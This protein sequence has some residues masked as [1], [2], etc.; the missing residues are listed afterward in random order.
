MTTRSHEAWERALLEEWAAVLGTRE[1][2]GYRFL[3]ACLTSGHARLMDVAHDLAIDRQLLSMR[4]ANARLGSALAWFRWPRVL[5]AARLWTVAPGLSVLRIAKQVGY[6][7]EGPFRLA[8]QRTLGV[9]IREARADWPVA[10]VA[11][12]FRQGW[13]EPHR[14]TLAEAPLLAARALGGR[15][16][17]LRPALRPAL[18]R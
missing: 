9:E 10:R 3:A 13:L 16:P 8:V 18:R 15:T 2:D 5:Q 17:V 4:F 12:A 11:A 14:A 6:E 1:S 7:Y